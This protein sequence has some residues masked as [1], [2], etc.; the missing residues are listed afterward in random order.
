VSSPLFV[1]GERISGRVLDAV[2]GILDLALGRLRLPIGFQ[3]GVAGNLLD[4]SGS[5]PVVASAVPV[6]VYA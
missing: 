3:L 1:R 2:D 6:R 4:G 5:N